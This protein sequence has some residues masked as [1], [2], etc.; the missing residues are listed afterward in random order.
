M[1]TARRVIARSQMTRGMGFPWITISA[2][3]SAAR[4]PAS[5]R[6][7]L[8]E[9][10]IE[11]GITTASSIRAAARAISASKVVPSA[12][13]H[14]HANL[15]GLPRIASRIQAWIASSDALPSGCRGGENQ[16]ISRPMTSS[17]PARPKSLPAAVFPSMH[18]PSST[19]STA[20]GRAYSIARYHVIFSSSGEGSWHNLLH[21]LLSGP[22]K[23]TAPPPPPCVSPSCRIFGSGKEAVCKPS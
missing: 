22:G 12:R 17:R 1:F 5:R 13:R 2:L 23:R 7:S 19:S 18:L 14:C 8:L 6:F 21:I 11:T 16:E 4:A 3:H 15:P 20:S 9:S 10:R